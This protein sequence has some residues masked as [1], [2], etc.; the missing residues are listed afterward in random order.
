[1]LFVKQLNLFIR[2]KLKVFQFLDFQQLGID[3]FN[4]LFFSV[5]PTYPVC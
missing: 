4:L 2:A 5:H 1:M 3:I